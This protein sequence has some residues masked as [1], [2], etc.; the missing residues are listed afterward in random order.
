MANDASR[1]I[2]KTNAATLTQL[3]IDV[4]CSNSA[5]KLV[6]VTPIDWWVVFPTIWICPIG[7]WTGQATC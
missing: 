5:L 1:K 7:Q 4:L 2:E 3:A 6:H